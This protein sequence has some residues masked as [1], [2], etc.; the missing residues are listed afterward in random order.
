M[1]TIRRSQIIQVERRGFYIC[2]K[3]SLRP[4]EP[5]VFFFIPDGK[6]YYGYRKPQ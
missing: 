4:G 2:D 3:P 6:N 1:R 5:M